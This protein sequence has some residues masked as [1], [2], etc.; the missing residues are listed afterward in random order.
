MSQWQ[1]AADLGPVEIE[2]AGALKRLEEERVVPRIWAK[3]HTV[4]KPEPKEIKNRLGWLTAAEA[5]EAQLP[6]L[7]DFAREVRAAGMKKAL[8]LGMGG[9]SLVPE[10]LAKIFGLGS[11]GLEVA[12]L[13][14]TDPGAV[15]ARTADHAPEETLFIVAS[16]SGTTVE[17]LSFF[18]HFYNRAGEVLGPPKVGGHFTAITDPQ[19]RLAA[20]AQELGFRAVFLNDP[21]IGGRYSALSLFGLVP[22]VLVGL[23]TERL[24]ARARAAAAACGPEASAAENPGAWL[25]VVLGASALRGRD[26]MTLITPERLRPLGDWV[27]QLVAESTGKEGRGILPVVGEALGLPEVYGEDRLF[28]NLGLKGEASNDEALA[29]LAAAGQPIVRLEMEDLYDLGAQFFIWEMATAVAGHFL[30]VNPFDQ[31]DVEAAKILAREMVAQY[32]SEGSLPRESPTLSLA[33]LDFFGPASGASI[34]EALRSFLSLAR[35]GAYVALQ[36]Y[37]PPGD[38]VEAALKILSRRL[39]QATRLAVTWGFGPRFLHSTGQLH[40]GDAGRGLFIQFSADQAQDAPIPDDLG[41]ETS[42]ITFGLLETAQALGDRRALESAGRRVMRIHLGPD[43]LFGLG[44][45]AEAL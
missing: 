29:A 2:V 36:A 35:P 33:G 42:A 19:S 31:P 6:R 43:A 27:E 38:E 9:S 37:L 12:I 44:R 18:K 13:D 40:K 10:V 23:D 26:K 32:R 21:D 8:L 5:F 24:L 3:D 4:W 1:I 11:S 15:L 14:S 17:P 16:K 28:V 41:R 34:A 7:D 20:Q 45:L 39:R 30:K 22:A 25:G